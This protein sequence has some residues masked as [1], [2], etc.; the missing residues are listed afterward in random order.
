MWHTAL[1]HQMSNCVTLLDPLAQTNN[2]FLTVAYNSVPLEAVKSV[3]KN[4]EHRKK[5][6]LASAWPLTT[7]NS[8][9]GHNPREF[10]GS[11][12]YRVTLAFD[13]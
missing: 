13:I 1:P 11:I 2:P 10:S 7:P 6:N 4:F 8:V 3:H 5:I 9:R 12:N